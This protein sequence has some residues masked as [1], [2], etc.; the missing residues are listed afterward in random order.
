MYIILRKDLDPTYQIIQSGHALFEHALTLTDKPS[1]TSNFCLLEAK[2]E[3][4]LMKIAGKLEQ[5]DINLTMFHEP[6]YDTGYTA[7]AAGPI[8]G[9]D[10]KHFKKFKFFRG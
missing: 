2:D 8:Y 3:E 9:E 4:D 1:Q 5:K 7:I 6:D 10:R